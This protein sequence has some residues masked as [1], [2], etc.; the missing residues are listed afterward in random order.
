VPVSPNHPVAFAVGG[1]SDLE[2]IGLV[3]FIVLAAHLFVSF[4]WPSI[5]EI[6]STVW[7]DSVAAIKRVRDDVRS[8]RHD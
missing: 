2:L 6:C 5:R 4:V 8:L 3:T 1:W 7:G